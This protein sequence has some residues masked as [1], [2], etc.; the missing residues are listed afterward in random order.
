MQPGYKTLIHVLRTTPEADIPVLQSLLRQDFDALIAKLPELAE[1]A[2]N[3][4]KATPVQAATPV[5]SNTLPPT[6]EDLIIECV[7]EKGPIS[8]DGVYA[9]VGAKADEEKRATYHHLLDMRK[10]NQ[11]RLV[12]APGRKAGGLVYN[13]GWAGNPTLDKLLQ[14]DKKLDRDDPL[15]VRM[16][17]AM[18]VYERYGLRQKHGFFS[19]RHAQRT[20]NW[21][22]LHGLI[23]HL[24]NQVRQ[25][26]S[27]EGF[28][29]LRSMGLLEATVEALVVEFGTQRF[30]Q[31]AV[32][33]AETRLQ[34]AGMNV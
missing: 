3:H 23:E 6:I 20:W 28:E 7:R 32:E 14:H 15:A 1:E 17:W 31:D 12:E 25:A 34:K 11:I 4:V 27:S 18:D 2:R 22:A 30:K 5:T 9:C 10:Q 29:T 13:E 26:G 16:A 8:H 19:R 33:A 21:I 24:E